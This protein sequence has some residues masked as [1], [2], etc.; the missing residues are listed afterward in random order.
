MKMMPDDEFEQMVF[1]RDDSSSDM[2]T[3]GHNFELKSRAAP[4]GRP[5][6][7]VPG[8]GRVRRAVEVLES[9]AKTKSPAAVCVGIADLEDTQKEVL[10]GGL[11]L[12]EYGSNDGHL[13]LGSRKQPF[14]EL[15]DD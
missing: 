6:P 14:L 3:E 1:D 15:E 2:E 11:H 12:N 7:T 5:K 9:K 8:K 10:A 13:L 4:E